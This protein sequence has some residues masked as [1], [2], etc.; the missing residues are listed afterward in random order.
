MSAS[1]PHCHPCIFSE[2]SSPLSAC[3]LPSSLQLP[4]TLVGCS[5]TCA[6]CRAPSSAPSTRSTTGC[7]SSATAP[8]ALLPP[9]SGTRTTG[10]SRTRGERAGERRGSSA[11]AG[12][13]TSAAS[14]LRCLL[15]WPQGWTDRRDRCGGMVKWQMCKGWMRRVVYSLYC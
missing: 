4:S 7:C 6:A 3:A 5:P 12:A 14:T 8:M 11:S 15:S 2:P 9:A 10:S 1:N 13:R